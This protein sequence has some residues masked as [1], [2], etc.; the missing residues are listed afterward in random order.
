LEHR[1]DDMLGQITFGLYDNWTALDMPP[2]I[3]K[4][5]ED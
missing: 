1:D 3:D 5:G 2:T 4:P